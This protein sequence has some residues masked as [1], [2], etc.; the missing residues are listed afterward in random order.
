MT[1]QELRREL[2]TLL[3]RLGSKY[4]QARHPALLVTTHVDEILSLIKQAGYKSPEECEACADAFISTSDN[5]AN[6]ALWAKANGYVKLTE[7]EKH[8]LE[9]CSGHHL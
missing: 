8:I 6:R 9:T 7:E 1:D 5:D 2:I 3:A 4:D